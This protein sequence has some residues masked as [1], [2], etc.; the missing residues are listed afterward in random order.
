MIGP[1][2]ADAAMEAGAAQ[3]ASEVEAFHADV[4]E[5]QGNAS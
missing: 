2:D 4:A 1:D 5:T 3:Y